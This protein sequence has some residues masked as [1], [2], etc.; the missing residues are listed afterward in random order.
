VAAAIEQA[1]GGNEYPGDQWILGSSEG[2]EPLDEVGAFYGREDWRAI[3]PEF[4]DGH[5]VA[6]SFFSEAGFRYFLPAFIL[7]DVAD[8]LQTADPVFHLV[9]GFSDVTVRHEVSGRA[10]E[11]T[12]ERR[13]FINPRRYGA[14]TFLDHARHR[15]SIFTREEAS[16]IVVYL[17]HV[18]RLSS[19]QAEH[20][21]IDAALRDFW[22]E[23][24]ASA[25]R[26][27]DLRRHLEEQAAYL[28]ALERGGG[29]AT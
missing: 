28:D 6:L 7:A 4:L 17:E 23:R 9:H 26:A 14:A 20:A 27:E 1:F 2:C 15:L 25:P 21:A 16:A 22:R 3:E 29:R 5:Y 8:L 10:F 11:I 19:R 13:Q 12:T 24:A 18:L